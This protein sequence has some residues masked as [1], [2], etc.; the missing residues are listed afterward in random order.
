ML[1][2][3]RPLFLLILIALLPLRAWAGDAMAV[4]VAA[5]MSITS[6]ATKKI[7]SY[8][9]E[10]SLRSRFDL[11]SVA[12]MPPNCPMHNPAGAQTG[13][14][15]CHGCDTCEL[16]LVVYDT[17]NAALVLGVLPLPTQSTET[18]VFF[19][20]AERASGFKPPIA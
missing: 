2:A 11:N 5:S 17:T 14:S 4:G 19:A 18:P 9:D 3:L 16:C 13:A 1:R 20:S 7:T 12:T 15:L 10:S 8:T 6:I